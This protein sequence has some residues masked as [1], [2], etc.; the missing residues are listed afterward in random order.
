MSD[1]RAEAPDLVLLHGWGANRE[2]WR[3]LR[4]LLAQRFRIHTPEVPYGEDAAPHETDRISAIAERLAARAP[5][6]CAVCGWSLGGAIALAWAARA[7]HQVTHLVLIATTPCFV[8]RADWPHG[9]QP[10]SVRDF[11]HRVAREPAAVL[12]RFIALQA[13]GD[14][15]SARVARHLKRSLA[16]RSHPT[17]TAALE[18]GLS[19]LLAVDLRGDLQR[20]EQ[21]A[22]VLHGARDA[23][24]PLAA[25]Q[26]LA[27][28]LPRA[29]LVVVEDAA[30]VPFVSQPEASAGAL[31]R[32]LDG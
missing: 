10:W 29:R 6:R 21:P 16:G 2:V 15:R 17:D 3:E 12:T 30:H 24:V 25:G 31:A 1:G 18:C 32:F 13:R 20:I 27:Q 9:L 4:R 19:L 22:F 26:Y 5:R 23:V 14:A 8:Q 11:A 28:H 7:P